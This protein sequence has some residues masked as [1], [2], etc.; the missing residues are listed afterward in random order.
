MLQICYYKAG[1]VDKALAAAYTFLQNN[2]GHENMQ[3]N[4]KL[5]MEQS[6]KAG[7]NSLQNM[8]PKAYRDA[9]ARSVEAFDK[10]DYQS[11]MDQTEKSLEAYLEETEDCRAMCEGSFDQDGM[12]PDLYIALANHMTY[13]L[14][15]RRK[16]PVRLQYFDG[17]SGSRQLIA[18]YYDYLHLAYKNL[19]QIE[20]ACKAVESYLLF[21]P[22]DKGMLKEKTELAKLSKTKPEWFVPRSEASK[23]FQRDE[24]ERKV[25]AYIESAFEVLMKETK[26]IGTAVPPPSADS[27]S[28]L[29]ISAAGGAKSEIEGLQPKDDPKKK[30]S[31]SDKSKKSTKD[32]SEP[33][34]SAEEDSAF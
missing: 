34:K 20:E 7:D 24:T 32:A 2:P 19:D 16:C 18:R 23:Y 12:Q 26:P 14:K 22:N 3:H 28:T 10:K 29:V 11:L 15:C 8:E 33:E 21:E 4:V 6:V 25:L 9:F 30:G 27:K 31:A 1:M 13:A 17:F 5:Y